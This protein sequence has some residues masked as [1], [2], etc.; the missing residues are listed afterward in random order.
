[1][2]SYKHQI[3]PVYRIPSYLKGV[4]YLRRLRQILKYNELGWGGTSFLSVISSGPRKNL[5]TWGYRGIL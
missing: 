4:K 1:M 2:G 5:Q 3:K